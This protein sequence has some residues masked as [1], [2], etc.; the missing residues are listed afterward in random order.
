MKTY[1]DF[2]EF[3]KS[4]KETSIIPFLKE[5]WKGKDKLEVL[6]RFFAFTNLI[7]EFKNHFVCDGNYNLGTLIKNESK[8]NY[9]INL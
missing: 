8:K 6:F 7:P 2:Y 4:N 5:S 1:I 3:I 9:L